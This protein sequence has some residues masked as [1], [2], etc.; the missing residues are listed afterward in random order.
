MHALIEQP[1]VERHGQDGRPAVFG[2]DCEPPLL[3]VLQ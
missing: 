3:G 1:L 2:D